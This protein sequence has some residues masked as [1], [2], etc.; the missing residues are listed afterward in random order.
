M[1]V[2]IVIR[3]VQAVVT[4][5]SYRV[6][7]SVS[8]IWIVY[9]R[10]IV[11]IVAIIITVDITVRHTRARIAAIA[12]AVVVNVKLVRIDD[13]WAIVTWVRDSV[14]IRVG[15]L[16]PVV[17][18]EPKQLCFARSSRIAHSPRYIPRRRELTIYN[19]EVAICDRIESII[20]VNLYLSIEPIDYDPIGMIAPVGVTEGSNSARVIPV[21]PP[22]IHMVLIDH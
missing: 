7:V 21:V 22:H 8:L 2:L 16:S 13:R 5:I 14:P 12:H 9:V 20:I 4:Y 1:V 6:S 11:R 15:Q 17:V 18:S 19:D 10:A 3:D